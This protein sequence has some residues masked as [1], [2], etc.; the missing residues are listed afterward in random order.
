[1]PLLFQTSSSPGTPNQRQDKST[2]E[3]VRSL[4]PLPAHCLFLSLACSLLIQS[5]SVV[6]NSV[7]HRGYAMLAVFF[8]FYVT[9]LRTIVFFFISVYLWLS[10][11]I[12]FCWVLQFF[13]RVI[14]LT[15]CIGWMFKRITGKL[16]WFIY[17]YSN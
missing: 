17:Y 13:Y 16:S 8:L 12:V 14:E 4:P 1:M 10:P 5:Q 2:S 6:L 11:K 15:N 7:Q 9:V 3:E